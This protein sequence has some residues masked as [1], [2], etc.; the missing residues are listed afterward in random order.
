MPTELWVRI[1]SISGKGPK[2]LWSYA[3]GAR[4]L[5]R[6]VNWRKGRK[7]TVPLPVSPASTETAREE[8][9][10]AADEAMAALIEMFSNMP[11]S[12]NAKGRKYLLELEEY[13]IV[14]Q[15]D[16]LCLA[17]ES[18]MNEVFGPDADNEGNDIVPQKLSKLFP[19]CR[20]S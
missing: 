12:S 9:L 10:S 6:L 8:P 5:L 7:A 18:A 13:E 2:G 11:T 17:F 3:S 15:R 16:E 1:V 14:F 20:R 19:G 4:R